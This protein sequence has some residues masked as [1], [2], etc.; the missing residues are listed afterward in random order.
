[1]TRVGAKF[2]P[3]S[4][5]CFAVERGLLKKKKRNET[6]REW[7]QVPCCICALPS[8]V[9]SPFVSPSC[10][11]RLHVRNDNRLAHLLPHFAVASRLAFRQFSLSRDFRELHFTVLVD[12]LF[13]FVSFPACDFFFFTRS[14]RERRVCIKSAFFTYTQRGWYCGRATFASAE[15]EMQGNAR[16]CE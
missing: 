4:H 8:V 3:H 10:W 14:A 15:N 1:M 9:T 6:K 16:R 5:S 7:N 2:K 11:P 12:F 13:L